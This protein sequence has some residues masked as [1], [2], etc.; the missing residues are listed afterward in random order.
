[1]KNIILSLFREVLPEA[2]SSDAEHSCA[3]KEL[4]ELPGGH[5]VDGSPPA[6]VG[7]P[8]PGG[9]CDDLGESWRFR[10]CKSEGPSCNISIKTLRGT[11]IVYDR[12]QYCFI[13]QAGI[14]QRFLLSKLNS[15]FGALRGS[16][17][18]NVSAQERL[19]LGNLQTF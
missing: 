5:Q 8:G 18:K 9:Q 4:Y 12:K 7:Q 6:P 11:N 3:C 10:W 2:L 15:L 13:F 1:M 19:C 16:R 17:L 14:E